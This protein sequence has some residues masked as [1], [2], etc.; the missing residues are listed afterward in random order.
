MEPLRA[1]SLRVMMNATFT[2]S[3]ST[4]RCGA[5]SKYDRLVV[6][7]HPLYDVSKGR[8]GPRFV[9]LLAKE[10][11]VAR[12]RTSNSERS[13]MLAAAVLQRNHNIKHAKDIWLRIRQLLELWEE[14][15]TK[16]LIEEAILTTMRD[17]RRP[18][19]DE[20]DDIV[21]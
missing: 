16:A 15:K 5:P 11:K 19:R 17:G 7:S 1:P 9:S 20:T 13:M 21:A 4:T 12:Q 10:L 2:T 8:V 6:H 18:H 14:R 3:G